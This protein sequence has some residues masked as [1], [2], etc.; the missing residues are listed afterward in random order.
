MGTN[1]DYIAR[2]ESEIQYLKRLLDENGIRYDYEAFVETAKW[3]ESVEI[4][5]PVLTAD[6]RYS[7][8]LTFE[9][10]RMYM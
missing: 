6:M 2:L 3:E 5:F 9:G 10:A 8:I 7:S 1:N 4:E